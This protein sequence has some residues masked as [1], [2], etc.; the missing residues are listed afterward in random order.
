MSSKNLQ[1]TFIF[2]LPD[3]S[4]MKYIILLGDGMADYSLDELGGRTPLE[5][6]KKPNID[7][8]AKRSVGG[9]L[10]TIPKGMGPGSDVANL[11]ILGY[12]PRIYY[13]GRGPLEAVSIGVKLEKGEMAFRCNLITQRNGAIADYSA[14]HI[15]T[16]EAEELIQALDDHFD[17]GR[18]YGG[19]SYRNLF[20]TQSI[21]D[22]ETTPPHDVI[23]GKI[24]DNLVRPADD[25]RVASLNK[26]IIDSKDVLE[27]LPINLRRKKEGKNPA[28]MIWLWGQGVA[29]SMEPFHEK[30]GI[31]GAV[32]S[33]VDL[34]KGIG[35]YAGM[36]II[37]VP[38][39]TGLIDTNWEGKADHAI[40]ALEKV[41][42]VYLHVEAIDEAS[43]AGDAKMKVA[44]IEEF[45]R[46]L[47]GRLLENLDFE[48][49]IAL[50]PDHYTPISIKTHSQDP[51]PYIISA[52]KNKSDG[53]KSY[54]EREVK[55]NGSLGIREGHEFLKMFLE[56]NS[57]SFA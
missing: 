9:Y 8:L 22:I 43:H 28:N 4:P 53:L 41:D 17:L 2:L 57:T 33:A 56:G 31:R 36:E 20:V 5:A 39:S 35:I 32:I 15:S 44:A 50:L 16:E 18:F 14:G 10:R 3:S 21:P 23:G 27:D 46:R 6:A 11:S 24:R 1:E 37:E 51:V 45:D 29:P 40:K 30:H 13:T 34:I 55:E 48:C 54:S 25:L 38:N 19:V 49:T 42:L 52:P 47:V 12:D 26:M 7:A